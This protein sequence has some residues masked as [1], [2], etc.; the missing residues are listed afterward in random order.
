MTK[1]AGKPMKMRRMAIVA[2]FALFATG[3]LPAL[4]ADV[5]PSDYIV[6]DADSESSATVVFTVSVSVERMIAAPKLLC[7]LRP[8]QGFDRS[9]SVTSSYGFWERDVQIDRLSGTGS[10]A[11]TAR[12]RI[13][14]S[15]GLPLQANEPVH[16]RCQLVALVPSGSSS[17]ARPAWVISENRPNCGQNSAQGCG[18]NVVKPG[19]ILE[20]SG[21][22][23]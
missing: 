5:S 1:K 14:K 11:F 3:P 13:I 4:G 7:Q 17:T 2:C 8:D 19:A 18:Q 6:V 10:V 9:S 21:E 20:L 16:V 12:L 22:A 15:R 23:R